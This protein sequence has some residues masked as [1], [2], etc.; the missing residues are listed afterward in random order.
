MLTLPTDCSIGVQERLRGTVKNMMKKQVTGREDEWNGTTFRFLEDKDLFSQP[1]EFDRNRF[2]VLNQQGLIDIGFFPNTFSETVLQ[3]M[4]KVFKDSNFPNKYPHQIIHGSWCRQGN[5]LS[6]VKS[7][8]DEEKQ[9]LDKLNE[10]CEE[11]ILRLVELLNTNT[12]NKI[13]KLDDNVKRYA[14]YPTLALNVLSAGNYNENIKPYV[15]HVDSHD[16]YMT[17]MMYFN[18]WTGGS[19]R[20]QM[21]EGGNMISLHIKRGD[22]VLLNSRIIRH[23]VTEVTSGV[24]LGLVYFGGKAHF[25]TYTIDSETK[26]R[27]Q[28]D[29]VGMNKRNKE[30]SIKRKEASKNQTKYSKKLKKIHK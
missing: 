26:E 16:L 28:I 19:L 4:E 14:K 12:F 25:S 29:K 21:V 13:A 18:S 2:V 17:T 7:T 5:L 23:Q 1:L 6:E 15:F 20:I 9:L 30:V 10:C 24:R 22:V 3:E 27:T 8:T 11:D